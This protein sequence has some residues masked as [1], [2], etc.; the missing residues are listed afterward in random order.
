MILHPRVL[1]KADFVL[2]FLDSCPIHIPAIMSALEW[3][4]VRAVELLAALF[5]VGLLIGGL[6]AGV[7]F[8]RARIPEVF[9]YCVCCLSA[10]MLHAVLD[11]SFRGAR[12]L[13]RALAPAPATA[14]EV[15]E[16]AVA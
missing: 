9:L 8:L 4:E 12:V 16:P 14:P 15:L 1:T 11:L 3:I 5:A 10:V 6:A 2:T 7:P 13:V